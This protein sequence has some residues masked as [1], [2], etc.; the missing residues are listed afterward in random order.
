M[1][2]YP[3]VVVNQDPCYRRDISTSQL[4]F[5][6]W[7]TFLEVLDDGQLSYPNP[8]PQFTVYCPNPQR[9]YDIHESCEENYSLM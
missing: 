9:M 8:A 4:Y 3:P 2:C 7:K 6:N 1:C 5:I